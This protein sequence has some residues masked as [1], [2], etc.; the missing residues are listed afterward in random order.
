MSKY[1]TRTQATEYKGC[2]SP[3][4]LRHNSQCSKAKLIQIRENI[5]FN[6]VKLVHKLRSDKT[7]P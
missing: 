7:H 2:I 4:A 3:L 1:Y 6:T 5:D